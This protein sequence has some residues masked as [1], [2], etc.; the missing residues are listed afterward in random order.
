MWTRPGRR[1][2]SKCGRLLKRSVL[3]LCWRMKSYDNKDSLMRYWLSFQCPSQLFPIFCCFSS[4]Y[5]PLSKYSTLNYFLGLKMKKKPFTHFCIWQNDLVPDLLWKSL[6][7]F[8]LRPSSPA[9]WLIGAWLLEVISNIIFS[10]KTGSEPQLCHIMVL[11]DFLNISIML[12]KY[13]CNRLF[14]IFLPH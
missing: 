4:F 13:V 3:L 12:I 14:N 1:C 9:P 10:R 7:P 5:L 2:I 6:G 11:F 8:L